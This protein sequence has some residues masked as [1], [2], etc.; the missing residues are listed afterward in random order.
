MQKI[1]SL[2]KR[3]YEG[4]SQVYDEVVEGS[5][6]VLKGEGV[7]TVKYDG[8]ACMVGGGKYWRRY[9]R[10][11][12]KSAKRRGAPFNPKD[13]AE[14]PP[15]WDPLRGYAESPDWALAGLGPGGRWAS[16]QISR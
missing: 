8:T 7:A 1:P 3:D 5:E 10:K 12:S 16:R 2:F 11:V 4:N 9:D 6:W 13:F 15:D 14:A